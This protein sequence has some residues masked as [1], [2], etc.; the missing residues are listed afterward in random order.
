MAGDGGI[1][2]CGDGGFHGSA[3]GLGLTA[4]IVGLTRTSDGD[5]YWMAA[6]NG[7]VFAFGN[8]DFF[9]AVDTA[10]SQP[11]VGIAAD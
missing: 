3:G 8:A 2:P 9:G 6:A 4:P 1:F 10:S 11:A 5:G 7:E